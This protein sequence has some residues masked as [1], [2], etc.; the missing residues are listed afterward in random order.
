MFITLYVGLLLCGKDGRSVHRAGLGGGCIPLRWRPQ[1]PA[2][3]DRL[4]STGSRADHATHRH[5]RPD[6]GHAAPVCTRYQT[7]HAGTIGQCAGH[8]TACATCPIGHAQ[9]DKKIKTYKY[10]IMLRV[11]LDKNVNIR[12]NIGTT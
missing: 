10:V 11:Q 6:A 1:P 5:T 4:H 8:W 7:D 3:P 2:H 9:T 12:Y